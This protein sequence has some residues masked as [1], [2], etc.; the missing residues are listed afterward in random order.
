MADVESLLISAALRE[1]DLKPALESKVT[2]EFFQD[3]DAAEVWGWVLEY[4]QEYSEV[5]T[6]RALKREFPT[7]KLYRPTEPYQYYVDALRKRRR[8][9]LTADALMHA[10]GALDA[11]EVEDAIHHMGA[12]LVRVGTETSGLRDT[13]LNTTWQERVER[14]ASWKNLDGALRGIP[15]GFP[16]LDRATLG[17]QPEQLVTFIGQAKAGKSTLMMTAAI[18]A[19]EFGST[20]LFVSFEMSNEEQEARHDA[21]RS[22]ISYSKL[23]AGRLSQKEERK[24]RKTLERLEENPAPF[25]LSSDIT[26]ATTVS[27]LAAKLEQYRPDVLYVDGVY[28]MDDEEGEPKGSSQALTNLTRSLKRLAQ[29]QRIPIVCST[30]VLGWKVGRR[31]GITQDSIGYSSSFAQDSDVIIAVENDDPEDDTVKKLKIVAARAAARREVYIR[32][33]WE[34]S[35]FTEMGEGGDPDGETAFEAEV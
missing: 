2:V 30:Q 32:W 34:H 10:A 16:T 25:L 29:R 15:T 19:H 31:T 21:M 27:G 8:F 6:A 20:P 28:L 12:G 4:W 7:F 22:G 11:G 17:L 3:S 33:D 5:P 26:S 13:N 18:N 9:A 35:S 1:R 23:L 24:L 14:Y